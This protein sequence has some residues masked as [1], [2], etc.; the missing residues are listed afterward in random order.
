MCSALVLALPNFNVPFIIETNASDLGMGAVLMQG[1]RPIA[2]LS[3]AL[4]VK[5][6]LL[7]TYEKELLAL[8][9]A[10]Q[11]WRHYLQ[12]QSFI[13]KTDHLSLKFLLE[14]KLTHAPQHKKVM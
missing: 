4:G 12:G 8:L 11:K 5:N 1:R 3:K 7:S 9:T 6:K 2:F 14:Q 10:V 13:I